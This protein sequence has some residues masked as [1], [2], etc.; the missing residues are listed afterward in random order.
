MKE[1]N[2]KNV[3][4]LIGFA[5]KG[6]INTPIIIDSIKQLHTTFG[7]AYPNEYDSSLLYTA[8]QCLM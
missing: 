1:F 3:I 2:R 8:E 6:P 5:S 7:S 4:A